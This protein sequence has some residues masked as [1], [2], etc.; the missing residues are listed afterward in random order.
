[1]AAAFV[2]E[3]RRRGT[4]VIPASGWEDYDARLNLSALVG[5]DLVSSGYPEGSA[6]LRVRVRIRPY[7]TFVAVVA[8]ALV[9]AAS[10]PVGAALAAVIVADSVRGAQRAR[11]LVR[12]T[13]GS[14]APG[15]G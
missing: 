10:V 11:N 1:L 6:Q 15:A 2:A 13:L 12:R 5:G 3:L 9:L 7:A 8:V 4:R 14:A